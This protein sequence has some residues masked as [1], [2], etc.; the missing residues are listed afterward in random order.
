MSIKSI[1]VPMDGE[2]PVEK[3]LGTA[4]IVANRFGSHITA[5]H[6]SQNTL[7][8]FNYVGN[9][10]KSLKESVIEEENSQLD[11]IANSIVQKLELFCSERG[12]DLLQG[13]ANAANESSISWVHEKGS[14]N[15]TL[16]NHARLHDVTLLNRPVQ[17][18]SVIRRGQALTTT[19][20]I[21]TQSGRPVLFVPPDWD[22]RKCQHAV[23]AWNQ[24]LESSRAL[25]MTIPWL[26]Q[27][28]KVSI[29]VA[30]S[31][32]SSG[33]K[34]LDYL[35]LH[36]VRANVNILNRKSLTAGKRL[37]QFCDENGGDFLIMGAYG[38]PLIEKILFGGVTNHV[39]NNSQIITVMAH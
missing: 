19:E 8:S 39:L 31:R 32:E 28:E 16:V 36:R 17:M 10:S 5:I 15:E 22:V 34:L 14:I 35:S 3:V 38:P 30:K 33:Q 25:A 29:V 26:N 12:L 20:T 4:L 2:E 9:L 13:S 11:K 1:L 27:M 24:S 7:Q 37:L 18:N 23:I 21:L 6:V